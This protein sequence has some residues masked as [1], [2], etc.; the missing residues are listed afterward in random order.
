MLAGTIASPLPVLISAPR[1]APARA[2]PMA[3]A[4][5]IGSFRKVP[6]A[7]GSLE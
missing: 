3:V 4:A 6:G 5:R 7:F 1:T 2:P